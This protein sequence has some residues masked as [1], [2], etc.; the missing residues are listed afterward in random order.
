MV[1][2]MNRPLGTIQGNRYDS[3]P[4]RQIGFQGG[5]TSDWNRGKFSWFD[6]RER[7][8][9]DVV[10]VNTSE[11]Y[12][13]N[14]LSQPD[15]VSVVSQIPEGTKLV[16]TGNRSEPVYREGTD[17]YDGGYYTYVEV[18]LPDG[19]TGW[20][21]DAFVGDRT[22]PQP[23]ERKAVKP[24]DDG[25]GGEWED[26]EIRIEDPPILPP[27]RTQVPPPQP[28][29]EPV[30]VP[31]PRLA[32][33]PGEVP[34]R[35][36]VPQGI[37]VPNPRLV[38]DPGP[39]GGR[40]PSPVGVPNPRLSLQPGPMG[41]LP[42]AAPVPNPRL[43][44][45]PG[46]NGALPQPTPV[47]NPRLSWNPGPMGALPQP[48]MVPNPRIGFDLGAYGMTPQTQTQT[49]TQTAT[50]HNPWQ[51]PDIGFSM[52]GTMPQL[53]PWQWAG[54]MGMGGAAAVPL[55]MGGAGLAGGQ[56]ASRGAGGGGT[57][58]QLVALMAGW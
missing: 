7:K 37:N 43:S 39:V 28:V 41:A 44:W 56:A 1:N 9:G 36:P 31:N 2:T 54:I 12:N 47:P 57:L 17:A 14:V 48:A 21:A 30:R 20:V 18:Q 24:V 27:I 29:T 8:A 32:L 45:N 6:Q 15:G 34:A 23:L 49:Q 51:W 11:G 55:I 46:P 16:Y 13:L 22:T 53:T 42:Q 58:Q 25:G 4:P 38:L 52:D 10:Y 33:Q 19:S 35:V 40:V 50:P 3:P 26:P 5:T